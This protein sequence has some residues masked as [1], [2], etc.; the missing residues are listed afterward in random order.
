M[1]R[2]E[3]NWEI[4]QVVFKAARIFVKPIYIKGELN[5]ADGLSRYCGTNTVTH[6]NEGHEILNKEQ[7][8]NIVKEN[9]LK[10]G[11]GSAPT[12]KCNM[13]LKYK[14]MTMFKDIDEFVHRCNICKKGCAAKINTKN[15]VIISTRPNEIWEIDLIGRL[16]TRR[17]ESKF[18]SVAIDHYTK[19]LE[20]CI[21]EKK[22]G[23][24]I[25]RAFTFLIIDKDGIPERI[26]TD[27]ELEFI[28]V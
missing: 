14:W 11:H 9:H 18:I 25:T 13:R 24:D 10:T 21:L 19:W 2:K 6:G 20:A 1:E 27:S 3:L 26:I 12:M 4:P 23:S 22:S 15:K 7:K 16:E 28:K 5:I 17:G 8:Q